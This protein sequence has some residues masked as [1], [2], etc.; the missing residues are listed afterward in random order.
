MFMDDTYLLAARARSKLTNEA[1]KQE[2]DLRKLVGHANL[3]DNI[4]ERIETH[5]DQLANESIYKLSHSNNSVRFTPLSARVSVIEEDS[6][7]EEDE[8]D[9]EQEQF[10]SPEI[11]YDTNEISSD[12]E[13]DDDEEGNEEWIDYGNSTIT[14]HMKDYNTAKLSKVTTSSSFRELSHVSEDGEDQEEDDLETLEDYQSES[15]EE[16]EEVNVPQ[17]HYCSDDDSDELDTELE[18]KEKS[19]LFWQDVVSRDLLAEK[20]HI[21]KSNNRSNNNHVSAFS[22]QES[23]VV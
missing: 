12:D 23:I 18:L 3:L 19:S 16:E 20:A 15:E 1:S 17:L 13:S 2:H 11:L 9:D 5:K 4:M 10:Q 21:M 22:S 6:S 14:V 7:D 8:D